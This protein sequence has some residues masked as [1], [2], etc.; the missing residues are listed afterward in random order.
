MVTA[1]VSAISPPRITPYLSIDMFKTH[2]SRGVS[3]GTLVPGA[4][5]QDQDAALASYIF[6]ATSMID[7]W[8]STSLAASVDTDEGP[9]NY[10]QGYWSFQ[11]RFRP[12][13]ALLG[14]SVGVPGRL[15][16]Y[17]SLDGASVTDNTIRVPAGPAGNWM[18]SQGPIQLGPPY[19]WPDRGY[20]RW[21]Y[22]NG[23]PITWLTQSEAQ[24]ATS[25]H[26]AD[27]TGILAGATQLTVWSGRTQPRQFI[28][29]AVSTADASGF[30]TGPGTVVCP[31]LPQ[32]IANNAA[33]PT[34]VTGASGDIIEAAVL[35]TRALIKKSSSGNQTVQTTTGG[36]RNRSGDPLG[37]GDDLAEMYRLLTSYQVLST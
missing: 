34:Y 20:G 11:P 15:T 26:V 10:H 6:K 13:V 3:V 1:V 4:N 14:F 18:S 32:D 24:G 12:V 19:A 21:T 30:G 2:G 8:L 33:Y 35:G 7:S 29:G 25:L 31:A 22:C 23:F 27:T 9:L 17:T 28:A 36:N 16:A 37:Y 5:P